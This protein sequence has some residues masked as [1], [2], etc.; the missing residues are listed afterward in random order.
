MSDGPAYKHLD[1][2]VFAER[3]RRLEAVLDDCVL[4]PRNCHVNRN[5]GETGYCRT[6]PMPF[7]S[8]RGPHFG[9]ERPLVGAGGSGTIFFGNCNLGCLFCQ[10][11]SISH[12]GE[13]EQISCERLADA[14][15]SLQRA[16]CHNVNLVT[17]THQTPAIARA[18]MIASERGLSVPIVYNCGGYESVETL[19]MLEGIVDIYMPDFKYADPDAAG[20][21]SDAPDYP[22]IAKAAIKEMHRQVGDLVMDRSGIAR[23]GL[24]VRHL[25][26]P[27]G[28]AGTRQVVNFIARE[29]S[30]DTYLNIMDQYHPCYK[31]SDHPLLNR[32]ITAREYEEA[33]EYALKAGIRRIDGVTI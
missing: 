6:G 29:I 1:Q 22:D 21:Y 19:G 31:A 32:R 28:L 24:L 33:V 2:S 30:Q 17:P 13:G 15:L 8:S 20:R 23:R 16:G 3:V 5:G 27:E 7:V 26:L 12:L 18:I 9:E 10:N 14:M 4:C 25:V 11:Y